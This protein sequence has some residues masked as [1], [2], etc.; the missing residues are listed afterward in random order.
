MQA[1]P[2]SID[3]QSE[4]GAGSGLESGPRPELDALFKV[5]YSELKRAAHGIRGQSRADVGMHTTQLVHEL[6]LR[7]RKSDSADFPSKQQFFGYAA[8]AMRSILIDQA[9]SR[10]SAEIRDQAHFDIDALRLADTMRFDIAAS[11]EPAL[12]QLELSDARSAKV[13]ELHIFLELP[14]KE[15]AE[16]LGVTVR[17]IDR[18]WRF[19]RAFLQAQMRQ[20]S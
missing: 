17:T 15:I 7:M 4:S 6:Y 8:R 10:V 13:V 12:Q 11:L 18:D 19:A 16:Q 14:L 1:M 9:R 3:P 2:P 20:N 5:V